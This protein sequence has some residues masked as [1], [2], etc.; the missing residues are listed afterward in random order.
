MPQSILRRLATA[1]RDS[2]VKRLGV[3]LLRAYL[4]LLVVGVAVV[5][6][7]VRWEWCGLRRG[8]HTC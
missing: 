7:F 4:V 3:L 8:H 6:G 2:A 1:L 5:A